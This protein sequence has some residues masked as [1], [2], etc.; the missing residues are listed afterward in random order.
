MAISDR[1]AT[2]IFLIN[3]GA[4]YN[5]YS[6]RDVI[7]VNFPDTKTRCFYRPIILRFKAISFTIRPM[8]F[9]IEPSQRFQSAIAKEP[10]IEAVVHIADDI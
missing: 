5:K 6:R 10:A 1:L 9:L 2:R 8:L 3:T 7:F 4:A